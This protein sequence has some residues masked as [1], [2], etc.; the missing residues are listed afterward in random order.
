MEYEFTLKYQLAEGEDAD[1][2]LERLAEAGCD[3]ALVGIG[4]PGRLALAF[5]RE[6]SS[7][8]EAIASAL[9]DVRQAVPGA[10]LIEATPDLVGLTDVAE[11]V[12][13]SRQNMR[14]LMLAHMHSFPAPIHEGSTS[15]WHLAEVLAWLQARGSYAIGEQIV[16]LAREAMTVNVIRAHERV[17]G[18]PQALA[19]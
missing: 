18:A 4:Q 19:H 7:A 2:L 13:V 16:E 3:D 10:R 1:A 15:L 6:S 5:V 12:G 9:N 14:K 11:L 17:F 8:K